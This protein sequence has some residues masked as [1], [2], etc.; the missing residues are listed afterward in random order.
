MH[1]KN[2]FK[3][4]ATFQMTFR[5]AY[6]SVKEKKKRPLFLRIMIWT[7]LAILVLGTSGFF[8]LAF[9]ANRDQIQA[10][11]K[12]LDGSAMTLS[13]KARSAL[14][15]DAN[16]GQVL[17]QKNPDQQIGIASQSKM[18]TA[19]AILQGID[20]G[21][22]QWT[23]PV[24][25]SKSSD[26]SEKDTAMYA[27]LD[28]HAGQTLTIKELFTAMFTTSANDASLALADFAKKKSETQQEFLERWSKKLGLKDTVWYNAAGQVNDDAFDYQVKSAKKTAENKATPTD[29]AMLAYQI[30]KDYPDVKGYYEKRGLV[31]SPN[32]DETA[33]K[34]KLTEGGKFDQEIKG[35]LNNPKNLTIEGLKTGSTPKSGG[36]LTGLVK[37]QD[38]HEFITVVSGAGK[39]TDSKER[40]QVTLDAVNQVLDNYR[41]QT[42]EAGQSLAGQKVTKNAWAKGGQ[43]QLITKEKRTYWLKKSAKG[44]VTFA[45]VKRYNSQS[46]S[47]DDVVVSVAPN[48]KSSYLSG[49]SSSEKNVPLTNKE[50]VEQLDDN[51]FR[52]NWLQFYQ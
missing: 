37:D 49:V 3:R 41:N 11:G 23:T 5:P 26:W 28:I 27:H 45:K 33:T 47:D 7:L 6:T 20:N 24:T 51:G 17:G 16:T 25:I 44:S 32:G 38:G 18:L 19:Y 9:Y 40:Y 4:K 30:I 35:Q 46:L 13:V 48:L 52:K 39:Y 10:S 31:Y 34:I 8:G 14:V 42:V 21:D 12:P 29:L 2:P 22:Y 15:I 1:L 50:M 43:V 36:G